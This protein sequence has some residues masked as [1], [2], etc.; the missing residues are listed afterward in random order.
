MPASLRM[1][2]RYVHLSLSIVLFAVCLANDGYFIA[3]PNPRAWASAWGL[4][5]VGWMGV[6]YGTVAWIANP[7]LFFAW[8][9]FYLRR[10]QRATLFALTAT[11][12]MLSFLLTRTIV[13]SEAP[14]YSKVIGY[15]SGYWL[16]VG[17][18][19][20]L[21]VGSILEWLSAAKG[22]VASHPP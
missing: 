8:L 20:A 6:L 4:L 14:T 11:V 7:V 2:R 10:Y 17:S 9:M 16:W 21:L 19:L 1:F 12:L 13:S 15:G 22:K 5:L 18:A 3:G